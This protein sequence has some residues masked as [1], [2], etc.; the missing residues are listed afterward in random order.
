MTLFGFKKSERMTSIKTIEQLFGGG[1]RSVSA[2]PVRA[3]YRCNPETEEP[4][5]VLISV[6][7]RHFHHAV[8]RNR[9]KR[10]IREA[11]RLNKDVLLK[12][13]TEKQVQISLAFLW[14]ADQP[15]PSA[16]VNQSICR[17]LQ[18]ITQSL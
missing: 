15:Q 4:V 6:S 5:N 12:P 13:L 1:A 10:Q 11:Y 17:L 7:K 18:S 9:A 2:F 3:V 16:K 14:M 8:D